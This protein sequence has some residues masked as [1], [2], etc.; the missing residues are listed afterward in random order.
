MSLRHKI[1]VLLSSILKLKRKLGRIASKGVER[2]TVKY[3][4]EGADSRKSL[5]KRR[6]SA[7]SLTELLLI[8]Q[9]F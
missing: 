6:L 2:A 1:F 9:Q 5:L 4:K 3:R 8:L 7:L